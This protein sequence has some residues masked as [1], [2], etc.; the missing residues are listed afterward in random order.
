MSYE[1]GRALGRYAGKRGTYRALVGKPVEKRA[2]GRNRG[3]WKD[4]IR[5]DLTEIGRESVD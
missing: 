5:M 3:R 1:V 2:F 4:K